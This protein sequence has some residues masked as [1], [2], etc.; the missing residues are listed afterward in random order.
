MIESCCSNLFVQL[1]GVAKRVQTLRLFGVGV[2]ERL[3]GS[4]EEVLVVPHLGDWHAVELV[5]RRDA[6]F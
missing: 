5:W 3:R 1:E 4:F 2:S 6:T